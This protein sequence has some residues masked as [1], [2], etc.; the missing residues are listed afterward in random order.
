M[1]KLLLLA[2]IV[3]GCDQA[4]QVPA[5][6]DC[7]EFDY[8]TKHNDKPVVCKMVFCQGWAAWSDHQ[9]GGAATLWC[10]EQP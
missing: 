3:V 8:H 1:K 2:L 10:D 5:S 9:T 4:P 7:K 6:N